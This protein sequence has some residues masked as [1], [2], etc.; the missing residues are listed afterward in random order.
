[1]GGF[2]HLILA[3][4][5]VGMPAG[6]AFM[7]ASA[8]ATPL[9]RIMGSE[10][11]PVSLRGDVICTAIG[12]AMK[13]HAPKVR[14]RVEVRVLSPSRLSAIMTVDGRRLPA[15]NLAVSDGTIGPAQLR[16]FAEALAASAAQK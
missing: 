3:A 16:R 11:L 10:V 7:T 5:T 8:S 9:C 1:M 14:Y 13:S 4:S 2:G 15:Q 6:S 12:Q